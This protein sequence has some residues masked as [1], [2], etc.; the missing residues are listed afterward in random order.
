[1]VKKNLKFQISEQ[2][3]LSDWPKHIMHINE[4]QE[5]LLTLATVEGEAECIFQPC[6]V[7]ILYQIMMKCNLILFAF[8]VVMHC[9]SS[10]VW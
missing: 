1:L 3:L 7:T 8:T 4:K 2:P 9:K 10:M 5:N 6:F